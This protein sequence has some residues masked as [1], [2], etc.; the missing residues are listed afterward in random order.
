MWLVNLLTALSDQSMYYRLASGACSERNLQI[1][2]IYESGNGGGGE[3]CLFQL[4][5]LVKKDLLRSFGSYYGTFTVELGCPFYEK[6][7]SGVGLSINLSKQ[8]Y[9][10]SH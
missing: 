1:L 3:V 6:G 5:F 7:V 10:F 2:L 8:R 4:I 9:H